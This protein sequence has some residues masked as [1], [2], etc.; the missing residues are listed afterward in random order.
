M[1]KIVYLKFHSGD[2]DEGFQ[3][4]LDIAEAGRSPHISGVRGG[5]R[6]A[7]EVKESY[8][9]WQ[10]IYGD[11]EVGYNCNRLH[12][13]KSSERSQIPECNEAAERLRGRFLEW[14][15]CEK[16]REIWNQLLQ[17]LRRDEETIVFLQTEQDLLRKMPWQEWDLFERFPKAELAISPLTCSWQNLVPAPNEFMRIL[18]ILGNSDGIDIKAD[19][20]FL[21][22]LPLADV[23]FLVEPTREEFRTLWNERWDILFFA[24][25]GSS[26]QEGGYIYINQN[27]EDRLEVRELRNTL[28]EAIQRGLKLGIFNCC[29][30]IGL[31]RQLEDLNI[32]QVIVMREPVP[33]R[34]AQ[35]FLEYFLTDF[36]SG[37]SLYASVRRARLQLRELL[38]VDR[39]FPGASWLPVICQNPTTPSL[40]WPRPQVQMSPEQ[41]DR[42]PRSQIIAE[43]N[44]NSTG[45]KKN[46]VMLAAGLLIFVA[47][48]GVLAQMLAKEGPDAPERCEQLSPVPEGKW[49]YGGAS[50]GDVD[51]EIEI[52]FDNKVDLVYMESLDSTTVIK[53]LLDDQISFA[54][55]SRPINAEQRQKAKL[56]KVH[57]KE[58]AVAMSDKGD[59]VL[60][61]Y[62]DYEDDSRDRDEKI[63][64]AYADCLLTD[65]GQELIEKAGF[66]P[67]R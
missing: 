64:K 9:T 42:E 65:R 15:T 8:Q 39:L 54:V 49:Q 6:P 50:I 46:L 22:Q 37:Q 62:K 4:T 28:R 52:A 20:R 11:L 3:A 18:A 7:P 48:S 27:S 26:S 61:I 21:E 60:V 41:D 2:F 12:R 10:Q 1:C 40:E 16:F 19:R 36:S 23:K 47:V 17:E 33:D 58:V 45:G 51:G 5:L 24:G 55:S 31:A 14:L 66:I 63:G 32:P 25:H 29:E 67:I 56:R 35:K 38:Q 44:E 13:K 30:S 53:Q 57:L 34:F 43:V 59:R